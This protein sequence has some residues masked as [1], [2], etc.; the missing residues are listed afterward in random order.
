[1]L[2]VHLGKH[3]ELDVILRKT[4]VRANV[5]QYGMF[6]ERFVTGEPSKFLVFCL[7]NTPY[8]LQRKASAS[9]FPCK[10]SCPGH[11]SPS[12]TLETAYAHQD[13]VPIL[14]L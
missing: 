9:A 14:E 3:E 2:R 8:L 10:G 13:P 6:R 12:T 5:L 11:D 4:R 1:M 7:P